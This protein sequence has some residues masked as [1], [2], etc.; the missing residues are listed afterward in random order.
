[1]LGAVLGKHE[2]HDYAEIVMFLTMWA[3]SYIMVHVGYEFTIDKNNLAEYGKDYLIAM[4]AAGFPW[5]FVAVW[6]MLTISALPVDQAFLVARFAAPTSAGILFSMLEGAGLRDTWVFQKA[7]ILAIFDDL[8]TIIL[9]IPLK[10]FMVGF[11]WELLVT[12]G[13]MV[14]L[15]GVAWRKLHALKLPYSCWWT[16]VYA[17]VVATVCKALHYVTHH[18]I[19]MKPI[20]IE[21]LL[22]AFVVGCIID[23]PCARHELEYQRAVSFARRKATCL[24]LEEL[25]SGPSQAKVPRS[26]DQNSST[27]KG[28]SSPAGWSNPSSMPSVLSRPSNSEESEE[29]ERQKSEDLSLP[30]SRKVSEESELPTK[31]KSEDTQK[32]AGT[33][34]SRYG[35]DVAQTEEHHESELEARVQV[36]VSMI[37]MV[38]V[39]L[40]MPALIGKNAKKSD[41]TMDAVEIAYQV[42]VVSILMIL[43]KMF[44][45]LCYR[46]EA[47][48]AGRLA[49]CFGMCPRGEV[50]ASIIVISLELGVEGPAVIISMLALV[51]NLVCSGGF[52][53]LVKFLLRKPEGKTPAIQGSKDDEVVIQEKGNVMEDEEIQQSGDYY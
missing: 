17:L 35:L 20:H 7:R 40:S 34:L 5:V 48:I 47:G 52:I 25:E 44:P 50:G 8:D 38:L 18:Y 27:R 19:D 28:M 11:K 1:V 43:G 46:D 32:S 13:I 53:G 36:T 31:Q 42:V 49:L 15:L 23:T 6:F 41:E 21:V 26:K 14:L 24:N 39:G 9:M 10:M 16:L 51:I 37:F 22:P 33:V 45:L 3:L 29:P 12:V 2:Y 30:P 4:T